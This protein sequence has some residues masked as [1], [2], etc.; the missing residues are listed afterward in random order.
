MAVSSSCGIGARPSAV[1]GGVAELGEPLSSARRWLAAR[2]T[3]FPG[4][5][6]GASRPTPDAIL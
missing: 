4:G 6:L 2:W 3:L 5:I 1:G